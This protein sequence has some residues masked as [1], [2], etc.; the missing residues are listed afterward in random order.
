MEKEK[1][2]Y[3]V[4]DQLNQVME[5]LKYFTE[6]EEMDV[7]MMILMLRVMKNKIRETLD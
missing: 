1:T 2:L 3:D 5:D 4:V 7:P 6:S